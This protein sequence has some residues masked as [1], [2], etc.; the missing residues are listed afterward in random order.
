M[1]LVSLDAF[2][3]GTFVSNPTGNAGRLEIDNDLDLD[4][5]VLRMDGS[6]RVAD[7]KNID[8]KKSRSIDVHRGDALVVLNKASSAWIRS[9]DVNQEF[10]G[11]VGID[12]S[13]L[14]AL[15]DAS[16]AT[17]RVIGKIPQG[18]TLVMVGVGKTNGRTL[19]ESIFWRQGTPVFVP[20]GQ[21]VTETIS[22]TTGTTM[23][24]SQTRTL[25]VE[26]GISVTS[27]VDVFFGK[28]SATLSTTFSSSTSFTRS[29]AVT[30]SQTTSVATPFPGKPDK[31]VVVFRYQLIQI[32]TVFKD[33]EVKSQLENALPRFTLDTIDQ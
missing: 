13:G 5:T 18:P 6:G 19:S 16:F 14:I 20:R 27:E 3:N 30:K 21:T 25:G 4:I 28:V 1:S 29:F 11:K 31:D 26:L 9:I 15:D 24:E 8:R 23:T 17:P 32:I 12:A 7:S 10:N 22:E 2:I 33:G